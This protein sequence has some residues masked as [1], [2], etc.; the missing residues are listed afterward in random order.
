[1]LTKGMTMS[2][3]LSGKSS[4]A[5]AG[6]E[7]REDG[8]LRGGRERYRTATIAPEAST[9]PAS[10]RT[11]VRVLRAPGDWFTVIGVAVCPYC[12]WR[13]VACSARAAAAASITTR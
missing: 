10:I 8:G 1:M 12:A 7:L 6:T 3:G 2:E 9:S 4:A 13:S 11:P 5:E